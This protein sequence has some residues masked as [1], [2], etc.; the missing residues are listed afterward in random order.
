MQVPQL[1]LR[2]VC[3][4]GVGVDSKHQ[5]T[6]THCVFVV[7]SALLTIMLTYSHHIKHYYVYYCQLCV[8]VLFWCW[9]QLETPS[10]MHSLC[11]C[12]LVCIVNYHEG[13]TLLQSFI[14][15]TFY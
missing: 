2:V 10:Y 1:Q 4:C 7:W 3:C 6:C 8:C 15:I 14:V 12:G 9:G 5:A 11:V 13:F